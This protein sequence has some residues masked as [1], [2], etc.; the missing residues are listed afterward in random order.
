MTSDNKNSTVLSFEL[1][2]QGFTA[3]ER[4]ISYD[5]VNSFLLSIIELQ[6]VF[7]M[8][9]LEFQIFMVIAMASVQRFIR[10]PCHDPDYSKPCADMS[11]S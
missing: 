7:A 9:P 3:S 10:E 2:P 8:R 6:K 11:P 1:D 4:M 5:T